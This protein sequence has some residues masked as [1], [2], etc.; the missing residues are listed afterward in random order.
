MEDEIFF[1]QSKYIKEML[2]KF[3]LEDS[4]PT[5]TL[6]STE[7]ELSKDDEANFMD[8][9]M[10]VIRIAR[11]FGLL[12]NEMRDALSVE[13]LPYVFKKK[14]LI[15]MGVIMELNNGVCIWPTTRAGEEGNEA[16][17]EAGREAANERAGGFA[18][19]YRNMSQGDWQV[20]QA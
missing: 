10:F 13:P 14:S 8:R 7:I 5:K 3:G 19:M 1:N 4:K 17:E 9:G 11:S 16:K 2:K 15:P 18:K 12:T 20:R 6:M